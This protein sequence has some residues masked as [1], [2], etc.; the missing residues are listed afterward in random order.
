MKNKIDNEF[1]TFDLAIKLRKIGFDESCVSKEFG[2]YRYN[3]QNHFLVVADL[4]ILP[5]HVK[6]SNEVLAPLF[7]QVFDWFRTVHNYD[8]SI[9]R[10][11][12]HLVGKGNLKKYEFDIWNE[13]S[14]PK[15]V[16]R[17]FNDTYEEARTACIQMLINLI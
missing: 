2:Y 13:N 3:K 10:V 6:N 7:Q 9:V 4:Y 16:G 17:G 14:D 1:V 12:E 5:D 11:S 15:C 8:Y